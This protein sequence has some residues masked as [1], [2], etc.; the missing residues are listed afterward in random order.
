MKTQ[1]IPFAVV[2][3]LVFAPLSAGA[4]EYNEVKEQYPA[5]TSWTEVDWNNY[6]E[7]HYGS[8]L[9]DYATLKELEEDIGE[10]IDINQLADGNLDQNVL[11]IIERYNMDASELAAFLEEYDN[12][13][14]IHFA[15]DLVKALDGGGFV[16]ENGSDDSNGNA[17]SDNNEGLISDN[18]N[19]GN[20]S[21]QN[22]DAAVTENNNENNTTNETD[23]NSQNE[24]TTT[25]ALDEDQLEETYLV[26]LGWTV[27][28][29][30]QYLSD[31][32]ETDLNDYTLFKDLEAEVGP[33]ITDEN[34]LEV[35]EEYG[36]TPEEYEILLAEYGESPDDYYFLNDLRES[37][38]YYTSDEPEEAGT[39]KGGDM[40]DTATNSL[41]Y[42]LLGAGLITLGGL[43]LRVRNRYGDN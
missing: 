24:A 25:N 23:A 38:D 27:D 7:D 41:A 6:L 32:Y 12:R 31:N 26:P 35:I 19:E 36:L 8:Q 10:P 5:T 16:D 2:S 14:N 11:D 17:G 15:G 40:P 9:D 29:F 30:N 28:E 20:D 34:E 1:V 18:D 13:D 21:N 39:E 3:T 33:L 37:L 4:V 42:V 22:S 43:T